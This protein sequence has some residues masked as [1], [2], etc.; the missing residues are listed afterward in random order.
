MTSTEEVVV[1]LSLSG[2]LFNLSCC[3]R[4]YLLFLATVFSVVNFPGTGES[5]RL[6]VCRN[7]GRYVQVNGKRF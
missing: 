5:S 6:L 7:G 4:S 3:N 1:V 2:S